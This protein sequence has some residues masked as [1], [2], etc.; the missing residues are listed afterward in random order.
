[1]GRWFLSPLVPVAA[2][3]FP[4]FA[5]ASFPEPAA[6]DRYSSST[7]ITPHGDDLVVFTTDPNA[8]SLANIASRLMPVE[9]EHSITL[10]SALP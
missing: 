7:A 10:L 9:L 8:L 6:D 2:R 4:G 5:A 3:F 1:M